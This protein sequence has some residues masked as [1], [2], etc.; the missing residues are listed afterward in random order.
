MKLAVALED[1]TRLPEE[2]RTSMLAGRLD[3]EHPIA[4]IGEPR[5]RKIAALEFCCDLLDAASIID[6]MRS[7]DAQSANE[8]TRAYIKNDEPDA[9]WRKIPGNMQLTLVVGNEVVLNNLALAIREESTNAAREVAEA[10]PVNSRAVRQTNH[11][12]RIV[13]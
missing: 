12:P 7:W 2:V 1:L 4:H 5:L 10:M 13:G 8:P 6:V 9:A 3:V 11:R